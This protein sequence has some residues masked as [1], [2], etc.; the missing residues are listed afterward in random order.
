MRFALRFPGRGRA[1]RSIALVCSL[2]I[3][4]A[5]AL[6]PTRTRR[7]GRRARRR[8]SRPSRHRADRLGH[9][10]PP[11]PAAV[12]QQRRH[13]PRVLQL[14]P[15]R[16]QRR[17]VRRHVLLLRTTGSGCVIAEDSGPGEISS[18]WFTRDNGD[19]SATGRITIVLDGRTVLDD[20]LQNV[21]NGG[22]GA[23]FV[24]PLVA[25][26]DQSSGGVYIKMPMPYRGS[27]A[28]PGRGERLGPHGRPGRP[29]RR[30]RHLALRRVLGGP[31]RLVRLRRRL[32]THR[33]PR[34][35]DRG[36]SLT[37][38]GDRERD[39]RAAGPQHVDPRVARVFG[40][41]GPPAPRAAFTSLSRGC[42]PR[43]ASPLTIRR[44]RPAARRGP[45]GGR[46]SL[47]QRSVHWSS[48][49]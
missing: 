26:A 39:G 46:R 44:R 3:G 30:E 2:V 10:P 16:R 25:N 48:Q 9:L 7:A 13:H 40:D 37:F 28:L 4:C 5:L 41:R 31:V 1:R 19:V 21:V 14:R 29:V 38:H 18:I 33:R 11:R 23:P 35:G 24:S 43:S 49:R 15:G 45:C 17:R 34:L 42:P 36:R 20:S 32:D 6:G 22:H 27:L 47:S 12:P 8:R